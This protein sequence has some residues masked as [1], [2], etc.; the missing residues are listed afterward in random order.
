MNQSA[1]QLPKSITRFVTR[2]TDG[3]DVS[4]VLLYGSYARGTQHEQSDVDIIFVVEQGF[5]SEC[6]KFDGLLFEV[7]EETKSNMFSYWQKNFDEDRHWYLWKDVKVLYEREREGVEIVEHALSLV[8]ERQP[9]PRERTKNHR[10]AMLARL[11]KIRYLSRDDQGTAAI[12]LTE[13]ARSLTENWFKIRGH[14]VP[15]TKEFLTLFA[16]ECPEFANMLENFH[17]NASDL[18]GKFLQVKRMLEI[19]YK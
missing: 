13:F 1:L 14:F 17:L 4:A 9:W 7:L 8:S 6:V 12:L 5:K 16:E 19:V 11:E 10:L 3:G 2:R 18:S 15:S